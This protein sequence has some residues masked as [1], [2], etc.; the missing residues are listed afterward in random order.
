MS[1]CSDLEGRS[2]SLIPRTQARVEGGTGA[3]LDG[4]Q[5][6]RTQKKKN[7]RKEQALEQK[8]LKERAFGASRQKLAS[9][10]PLVV[11]CP[12]LLVQ[13]LLSLVEEVE[14]C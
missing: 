4:E 3:G 12:S 9:K 14:A 8:I 11:T 1:P 2:W 10:K 13:H 5:G 7:R 6:Q